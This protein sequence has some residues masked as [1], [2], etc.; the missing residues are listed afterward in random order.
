ML[1]YWYVN[2]LLVKNRDAR[3]RLIQY[4]KKQGCEVV[5]RSVDQDDQGRYIIPIGDPM[6]Q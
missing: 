3:D 4:F 6:E 2:D 1:E 5:V